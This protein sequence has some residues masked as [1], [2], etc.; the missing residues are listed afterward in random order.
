V[1]DKGRYRQFVSGYGKRLL[2]RRFRRSISQKS[3][4]QEHNDITIEA[5]LTL[6][7]FIIHYP[8]DEATPRE[9]QT[10]A[11]EHV[12]NR[13]TS[14]SHIGKRTPTSRE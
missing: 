13:K 12:D 2:K 3:L 14:R 4:R 11:D 6:T 8:D 5:S 7:S 10:V 9:Y 1:N